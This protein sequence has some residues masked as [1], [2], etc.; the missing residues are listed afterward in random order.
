MK[1][2]LPMVI[3][4]IA[5]AASASAQ[6]KWE[7]YKFKGNE[8]FEFKILMPQEEKA[9][10]MFYAMEVKSTGKKDEAGEETVEVSYTTRSTMKKSELGER[11]VFG[12]GEMAT[13]STVWAMSSA[14]YGMFFKELEL[15]EGEKLSLFGM[16]TLKV[17]GKAKI[18]DRDG[19][20]CKLF[21][22]KDEKEALQMEWVIDP[23]LALPLKTLW[24]DDDGKTKHSMELV[25]YKKQ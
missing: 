19:F 8:R 16:G 4:S 18:A 2:I 3:V 13:Y 24:F 10:E 7:P 11:T 1:L 14:M 17:T 21:Q 9:K 12:A 6:A 23:E 25:S 5:G 15:K 22:K 20:V